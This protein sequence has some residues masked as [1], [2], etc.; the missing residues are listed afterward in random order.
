MKNTVKLTE[1]ELK[2]IISEAVMQV[3]N[4]SIDETGAVGAF[5]IEPLMEKTL[6]NRRQTLEL[7]SIN[8]KN[9]IHRIKLISNNLTTLN[10][11]C[12][13]WRKH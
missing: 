8:T 3:L 11:I 5:L 13:E 9:Y 7:S 1:A 10:F 6:G 12:K 4:E 2:K